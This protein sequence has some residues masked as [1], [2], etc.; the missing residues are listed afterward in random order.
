MKKF[1]SYN[2]IG[3]LVILMMLN[4]SC[5]SELTT[6]SSR[7][8][9]DREVLSSVSGLN[10]VL[11]S[12]YQYILMGDGSEGAQGQ[13][14]Y[15]GIPGL[16]LYYDLGG[17]DILSHTNYGGSTCDS[18]QF[19]VRRTT[20]AENAT[21]IWRNMYFVIN[22]VNLILDAL[23]E[24]T[25]DN[26]EKS[27]IEGQC[28][29]LRGI[30]YFNLIFNYQ[31]TYAISKSK[32]GVI[33]RTSSS[34]P[35]EKGFS[36]VQECYDLIV[37]DL[38]E[39]KTLLANFNRTDKWQVNA[40]VTSGYLARV[41]QVMGNWQGA[42]TEASAVYNRN[43]TLM[44]RA[45]WLS[46]FHDISIPEVL[47]AI[48]NTNITNNGEN[49][50]FCY[51]HNQDPSY[52]ET[53]QG[54]PIFNFLQLLVD[55][56]YVQLFDD[57]DYRGLKCTKTWKDG[58][59]ESNHVSDDDEKG[60]MF[61]HRT[62]STIDNINNKWAYNKFKFI[63]T[64]DIG[65]HQ[66]ID[67]SIMRSSEMLLIMA[68]AAAQ[69]ENGNALTYLTTL[70][71]AR[72]ARLTTATEKNALLEE[73]YAERRKELLGEG[74]TGMYDL[75]RLQRPLV[76]FGASL[77][78]PAGHF[79]WGFQNMDGYNGSDA[80]PKGTIPSNDYRFI[81]QIPQVEFANNSAINEANDQ[82]PFSGTGN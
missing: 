57:T 65:Q 69:L 51:W 20:A 72:N 54:G 70:Q 31:Q 15:T 19:S 48:V 11:R 75:L 81:C 36:T 67:Y 59:P 55:D 63:G 56:K 53:M 26:A 34:D 39:A 22:Q 74:V 9:S 32:R 18:Y 8:V 25:G 80:E 23:P 3:L 46:G 68:E 37:S 35:V 16:C 28:K 14:V 60:V 49:T 76:R 41:Y 4:L 44:T 12:A 50:W 58:D 30:A 71:T 33:L 42:L 78:N 45:Q 64:G 7:D 21:K 27:L 40:D 82:N 29:T 66:Y 73:I 61:W 62:R 52:G 38:T 6:N 47:W 79:S 10:M 17:A 1:K 5:D 2:I 24:A 77:S 43:S 13:A